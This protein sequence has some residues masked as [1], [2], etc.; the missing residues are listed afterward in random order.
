MFQR[1]TLT[2]IFIL[3]LTAPVLGA[4]GTSGPHD[5]IKQLKQDLHLLKELRGMDE[6]VLE[7]KLKVVEV[8][9]REVIKAESDRAMA[10]AESRQDHLNVAMNLFMVMLAILAIVIPVMLWFYD[11]KAKED[12][13][14]FDDQMNKAVDAAKADAES[15]RKNFIQ[16]RKFASRS[17][18][19]QR[20]A[21]LNTHDTVQQC[22]TDLATIQGLKEQLEQKLEAMEQAV[23]D[24][25][26][27]MRERLA[28]AEE[29]LRELS[30][31]LKDSRERHDAIKKESE[32]EGQSVQVAAN[33]L[34][35]L[36]IFAK[37]APSE[38]EQGE[39]REL[40]GPKSPL[41]QMIERAEQAEE[42]QDFVTA[43]HLWEMVS[44]E[45]QS[46]EIFTNVATC[47]NMLANEEPTRAE[48][49]NRQSLNAMKKALDMEPTAKRYG[50]FAFLY[51]EQADMTESKEEA[52]NLLEKAIA[53]YKR[54]IQLT[55]NSFFLSQIGFTH[56]S[57]SWLEDSQEKRKQL[58]EQAKEYYRKAIELDPKD[59]APHINLGSA[60]SEQAGAESDLVK[61]KALRQEACVSFEIGAELESNMAFPLLG[62]GQELYSLS[63]LE[64]DGLKKQQLLKQ[65]CARLQKAV[66]IDPE[67]P[68][69]NFWLGRSLDGL[70][71]IAKNKEK[72]IGLY[73]EA[74]KAFAASDSQ[75]VN[76]SVL[77]KRSIVVKAIADIVQPPE[78]KQNFYLQ[79]VDLLE[80][81]TAINPYDP[82]TLAQSG[83]VLAALAD[84]ASD[85]KEI[86][87][88][89][90]AAS[91]KFERAAI[92]NPE[93]NYNYSSWAMALDKAADWTKNPEERR[94][95][96]LQAQEKF[97]KAVE[98]T[99]DDKN[100]LTVWGYALQSL[101][102]ETESDDEVNHY[103]VLAEEK[104]SRVMEFDVLD[105][106]VCY[107][108][109][110]IRAVLGYDNTM[111][112]FAKAM[113][114]DPGYTCSLMMIEESFDSL[115]NE[116][117]F[118]K[119]IKKHCPEA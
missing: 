12:R 47:A 20:Q 14:Q 118:Q 74:E 86:I 72:A 77:R 81:A 68:S 87:E 38:E 67:S 119:L 25:Q 41:E 27:T 56:I 11:Q 61:A 1:A 85:P 107:E 63:M 66:R 62:W 110:C 34:D 13:S 113:Q 64:S 24:G 79:A 78:K 36:K 40:A 18:E 112:A 76:E 104:F 22:T 54:A 2:L 101:A 69:I 70:A 39:V 103:L 30:G 94:W 95:L 31:I 89:S 93:N 73:E 19:E 48:E 96:R 108:L 116:A 55:P 109:A 23:R 9:L 57:K 82:L 71:E 42:D 4:E 17:I 111:D 117:W 83:L 91:R 51:R 114:L 100:I 60:L 88:F 37:E 16:I 43:F 15:I 80:K 29:L 99:P 32:A 3:L 106:V 44:L 75:E 26:R 35:K 7:G 45:E 50:F 97:A 105:V 8:E 90:M 53:N 28:Q 6:A 46:A 59:P 84:T 10:V 58:R 21:T 92:F 115:R 52:R 49:L 33:M 102:R 65:S 5:D 98:I